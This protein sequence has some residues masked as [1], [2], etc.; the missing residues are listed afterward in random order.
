MMNAEYPTRLFVVGA[1]CSGKSTVAAFLRDE[2]RVNAIDVDDEILR[3]ND[4]VWPSDLDTKNEV[5]LPRVLNEA[6]QM[7]SVVL[8]NSYLFVSHAA[9]LREAGFRILLLEVPEEELRR[10]D[11]SR[12]AKEGWT[13]IEWFD[14]HQSVIS[15]LRAHGF[16]DQVIPGDQEVRA[17]ARA[18]SD[19]VAPPGGG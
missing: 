15:E 4:G 2:F 17:V 6:L 10:R 3:L 13:N 5:L 12:F 8:F 9:Q 11:A 18:I 16:I 7:E 19:E 14:W 1:P